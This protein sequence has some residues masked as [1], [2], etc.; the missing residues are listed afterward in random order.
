MR[1]CGPCWTRLSAA[2]ALQEHYPGIVA[3]SKLKKGTHLQLPP[4]MTEAESVTAAASSAATAAETSAGQPVAAQRRRGKGAAA[5]ITAQP[6]GKR[7]AEADTRESKRKA[8]A[9][10]GSRGHGRSEEPAVAARVPAV[11]LDSLPPL[12]CSAVGASANGAERPPRIQ[13]PG[14]V[15]AGLLGVPGQSSG[16]RPTRAQK[17]VLEALATTAAD[18]EDE[19]GDGEGGA[20]DEPQEIE[21]L[22]AGRLAA[23]CAVLRLQERQPFLEGLAEL[24]TRAATPPPTPQPGSTSSGA[25]GFIAGH[26]SAIAALLAAA[27]ASA[28]PSWGE[29]Q[30][31][32][33]CSLLD[34]MG[35]APGGTA[36]PASDSC[37]QS[38]LTLVVHAM[39]ASVADPAHQTALAEASAD[40]RLLQAATAALAN[41]DTRAAR[42]A[43][44]LLD[45]VAMPRLA[46]TAA[47]PTSL[48]GV[49]LPP[50]MG[51]HLRH[52]FAALE[53]P[54]SQTRFLDA[55]RGRAFE[56]GALLEL[57]HAQPP[58]QAR[59]LPAAA[60]LTV[61]ALASTYLAV[62]PAGCGA[63]AA[64][65]GRTL[66]LLQSRLARCVLQRGLVACEES[67]QEMAAACAALHPLA[68]TYGD[69]GTAAV[70]RFAAEHC[71]AQV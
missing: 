48:L 11:P 28:T 26:T 71:F 16:M 12:L 23:L 29:A 62:R 31:E 69:S 36:S 50:G 47:V 32:E 43:A 5:A 41:P 7:E 54:L 2:L 30:R 40:V 51:Q 21:Q 19:D 15:A 65:A 24:W 64:T 17:T 4:M 57:M 22:K 10:A 25:A 18:S 38:L 70:L 61:A 37:A 39:A 42:T 66:L 53:Q 45:V 8:V 52:T 9:A 44:S 67:A 20:S 33:L 59:E 34:R 35:G 60:E 1:S 55:I 63:A 58:H 27:G 68:A 6:P 49:E 46:P 3:A 13:S 56:L 14:A